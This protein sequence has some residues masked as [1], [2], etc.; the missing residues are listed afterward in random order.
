MK[1]LSKSSIAFIFLGFLFFTFNW[2]I[3]DYVEPIILLGAIFLLI[4][5]VFCFIAISKREKGSIKYISLSSLF[6]V[7][8][9]VTWFEPFQVIR[10][11]T[12]IKNII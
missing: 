6:I 2:I 11:M 9:L 8:F 1:R 7:L 10:M 3:D 12:W 5:A 4:G